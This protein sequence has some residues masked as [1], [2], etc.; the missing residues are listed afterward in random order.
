MLCIIV[1]QA[2]CLTFCVMDVGGPIILLRDRELVSFCNLDLIG[3]VFLW[4]TGVRWPSVLVLKAG[5]PIAFD[6]RLGVSSL[7]QD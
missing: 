6:S 4:W 2:D 3:L 5:G 1:N 7:V